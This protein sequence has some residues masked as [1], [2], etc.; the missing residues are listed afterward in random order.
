MC[1]VFGKNCKA[2][3]RDLCDS[4]TGRLGDLPLLAWRRNSFQGVLDLAGDLETTNNRRV[5]KILL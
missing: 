1:N 3:Q 2:I 4:E 5:T